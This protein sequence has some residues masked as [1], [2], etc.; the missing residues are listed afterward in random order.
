MASQE[1]KQK[2]ILPLVWIVIGA[3]ILGTVIIAPTVAFSTS[4]KSDEA[5]E[6]T[7]SEV[8]SYERLKT[9]TIPEEVS[10]MDNIRI[11]RAVDKSKIL[12][13]A[14]SNSTNIQ[15][16]TNNSVGVYDIEFCVNFLG[17]TSPLPSS[18]NSELSTNETETMPSTM[19]SKPD[20]IA[21]TSMPEI[22]FDETS[23]DF[24]SIG[25]STSTNSSIS[26]STSTSTSD[27]IRT[28]EPSTQ[29]MT[30]YTERIKELQEQIATLN[31]EVIR[32]KYEHVISLNVLQKELSEEIRGHKETEVDLSDQLSKAEAHLSDKLQTI[33]YFEMESNEKLAEVERLNGIKNEQAIEIADKE[34]IITDQA[35]TMLT[36]ETSITEKRETIDNETII[37]ED[38]KRQETDM[39]NELGELQEENTDLI[40]KIS[41]QRKTIQAHKDEILRLEVLLDENEVKYNVRL[42]KLNSQIDIEHDKFEILE[43]DQDAMDVTVEDL[44]LVIDDLNAQL[45]PPT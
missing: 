39:S 32:L 26:I 7:P 37:N 13:I 11:V 24:S 6:S 12:R 27:S 44:L 1:K 45:N 14:E 20:E 22:E 21:S 38:L 43:E 29:T 19:D 23:L 41:N 16:S 17:L 9:A 5:D 33:Q 25:I 42:Q 36:L 18:I 10:K 15:N 34:T 35:E 31:D 3:L 30:D 8:L 28:L 2:Q 4:S 40:Q